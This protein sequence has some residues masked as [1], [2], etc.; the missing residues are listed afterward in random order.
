MNTGHIW[1]PWYPLQ[2]H[3]HRR[4]ILGTRGTHKSLPHTPMKYTWYPW[5]P[6][7]RSSRLE[8]T[9]YLVPVVPITKTLT[10][11]KYTW[12]PWYPYIAPPHPNTGHTWYPWYQLQKHPHR[13]SI[14]GTRG[15]HYIAPPEARPHATHTLKNTITLHPPYNTKC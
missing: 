6:L 14:L 5:Y 9:T 11:K 7:Y 15:T 3:P 12:Y 1:Y 4:S 8:Y 13:R 2:K 10:Q